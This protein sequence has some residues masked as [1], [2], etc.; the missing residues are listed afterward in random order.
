MSFA[1]LWNSTIVIA[2]CHLYIECC[3]KDCFTI[4]PSTGRGYFQFQFFCL[5]VQTRKLIFMTR[6]IVSW[7]QFSRGK[8]LFPLFSPSFI[9]S[10]LNKVNYRLDIQ[11]HAQHHIL[12][13]SLKL[14]A[15]RA[16]TSRFEINSKQYVVIYDDRKHTVMKKNIGNLP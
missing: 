14:A 15:V 12:S 9:L 10:L 6:I 3:V 8:K 4:T 13:F 5:Q 1:S 16:R 7:R 11:V 2:L